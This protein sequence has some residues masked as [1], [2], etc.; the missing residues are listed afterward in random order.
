MKKIGI[1]G[2]GGHAKIIID[3]INE[4]N[5]YNIIG[6][7]DDNKTGYI[8]EI[9]ILG[10]ITEIAFFKDKIE[11]FVIAIGN[12]NIRNKIYEMNKNLDWEI[13]IHPKSIVSKK[14]LIEKGTI[15][16]AGSIIQTDVKIGRHC[17]INTG[18]SIDHETI[19][20]DFSSICPKATICGQVKIGMCTFIG[21][22]S[23]VIQCINIGNNCIIGA[24][25][26][27]IKNI[28]DFSKIV[29]NPGRKIN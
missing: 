4:I 20:G 28:D 6:I 16:C 27:I 14:T 9:P 26:V 5:N 1:I 12:D 2:S 29:G 10:K 24:G 3:I 11:C 8:N 7:F 19:I 23:T 22:N 25:S 15:V 21:A 17:I 13:L 18:C